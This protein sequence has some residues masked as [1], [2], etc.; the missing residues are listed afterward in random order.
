MNDDKEEIHFGKKD[1]CMEEIARRN[2]NSWSQTVGTPNYNLCPCRGENPLESFTEIPNNAKTGEGFF[3]IIWIFYGSFLTF[4][5]PAW[6]KAVLNL[7]S[8]TLMRDAATPW[9]FLRSKFG[10]GSW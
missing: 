2:S 3:L 6:S 10:S 1:E 5:P 4:P 8:L 9:T 7:K